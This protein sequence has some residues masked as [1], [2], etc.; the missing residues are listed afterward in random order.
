MKK[1]F[2]W[3]KSFSILAPV[4]VSAFA[5][6]C[7]QPDTK[8]DSPSDT[9]AE[10]TV[11]K[12]ALNALITSVNS[13]KQDYANA[14]Y[15]AHL[16]NLNTAVNNSLSVLNNQS[17]T[18]AAVDS[19]KDALD[20]EFVKFKA[21]TKTKKISLDINK[22][23][24]RQSYNNFMTVD[25]EINA[26]LGDQTFKFLEITDSFFNFGNVNKTYKT[27]LTKTEA[28]NIFTSTDDISN[29]ALTY[30]NQDIASAEEFENYS[31]YLVKLY[32]N[33][34]VNKTWFETTLKTKMDQAGAGKLN[35]KLEKEKAV[36]AGKQN[37]YQAVVDLL[38]EFLKANN[39]YIPSNVEIVEFNY[40]KTPGW[41]LNLKLKYNN[42]VKAVKL[43][44]K[45][46]N[47]SW[48]DEQI[49]QENNQNAE[50]GIQYKILKQVKTTVFRI[51][52]MFVALITQNDNLKDEIKQL[53]TQY[54]ST[55]VENALDYV[56]IAQNLPA[57]IKNMIIKL[58]LRPLSN[59]LV[60]L[61]S[62]TID[63][64]IQK[65]RNKQSNQA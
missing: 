44:F 7:G 41:S 11:N 38:V 43:D 32:N 39:G 5:V 20:T 54:I 42:T 53:L 51:K 15:Q 55:S 29:Q 23:A 34:Y 59:K 33:Y 65:I 45:K 30:D 25:Q 14:K 9:K 13:Y 2:L 46:P 17:S 19:S 3:A 10:I 27:L 52:Q 64:S 8:K 28:S 61:V 58:T 57:I 37:E 4:A 49:Q 1:R 36:Q 47:A 56:P 21:N 24:L 63:S 22:T 50:T 12:N 6:S 35:G 16:N 26:F 60:Q 62:T 18:Q 48:S 40:N 31:Q